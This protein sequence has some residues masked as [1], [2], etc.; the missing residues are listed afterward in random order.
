MKHL[1]VSEWHLQE[2]DRLHDPKDFAT[3][4]PFQNNGYFHRSWTEDRRHRDPTWVQMQALAEA[5]S[6]VCLA[7][8]SWSAMPSLPAPIGDALQAQENCD[9]SVQI[10]DNAHDFLPLCYTPYVNARSIDNL[11]SLAFRLSTLEVIVPAAAKELLLDLG[12][13][14]WHAPKLRNLSVDAIGRLWRKRRTPDTLKGSVFDD[15]YTVHGLKWLERPESVCAD[16]FIQFRSISF[17][18]ICICGEAWPTTLEQVDWVPLNQ[19]R[20]SCVSL[21]QYIVEKRQAVTGLELVLN[22]GRQCEYST[23]STV[24]PIQQAKDAV[25]R[26]VFL[27]EL[28]LFNGT[29]AIDSELLGCIGHCIESLTL[30]ERTDPSWRSS[31]RPLLQ[32]Q[33]IMSLGRSCPRLR[34]LGIDVPHADTPVSL[35]ANLQSA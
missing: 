9:V 27:K 24:L 6:A 25:M 21:L 11:T 18:N 19:L 31:T 2:E 12:E 3:P 14:V 10:N 7:T 13:L 32:E 5:L 22:S 16:R 35:S 33:E 28:T 1:S 15:F 26:L 23:C 20:L 4:D 34:H 29:L 30:H 8:F 17:C